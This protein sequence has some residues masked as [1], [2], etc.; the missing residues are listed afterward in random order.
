MSGCSGGHRCLR[1]LRKVLQGESCSFEGRLHR[2]GRDVHFQA[3]LVPDVDADGSVRGFHVMTF[4]VT[5]LKTVEQQLQALARFDT[6]TGPANR[7]QYNEKLPQA[8]R[9]A[10][11]AAAW[12]RCCSSTSIASSRSTTRGAM[13]P[14]HDAMDH[15]LARG[16]GAGPVPAPG[17]RMRC[18]PL[19]PDIDA[20]GV[21]APAAT[22]QGQLSALRDTAAIVSLLNQKK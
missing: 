10:G 18:D 6:L 7:L 5:A 14:P 9:R 17:S 3:N 15:V 1:M 11:A 22:L 20:D 13:R 4:D 2:N 8:L 12:S 16:D 21:A 19:R